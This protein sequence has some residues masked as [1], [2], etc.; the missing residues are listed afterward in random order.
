M[1][2]TK[3]SASDPTFLGLDKYS[4]KLLI[5]LFFATPI[6]AYFAPK[7]MLVIAGIIGLLM[8]LALYRA[9]AFDRNGLVTIGFF[10]LIPLYALITAPLSPV[11]PTAAAM[12]ALRLFAELG[13]AAIILI[14]FLKISATHCH[15][16]V[17]ALFL[18]FMAA[19]IAGVYIGIVVEPRALI[20]QGRIFNNSANELSRGLAFSAIIAAPLLIWIL[21]H[22]RFRNW[23]N[24]AFFLATLLGFM[25]ICGKGTPVLALFVGLFLAWLVF[26]AYNNLKKIAFLGLFIIASFPVLVD[27]SFFDDVICETTATRGSFRH[28]DTIWNFV[29]DHVKERPIVGWGLDSARRFPGGN[30]KVPIL[31]CLDYDVKA[32]FEQVIPLHTHN[33]VLQIWLELGGLGIA[34]TIALIW[35]GM[36]RLYREFYALM[37]HYALTGLFGSLSIVVLMSF[38][39][40]QGWWIATIT[41]SVTTGIMICRTLMQETESE[42][43][44]AAPHT[45]T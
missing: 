36:R 40:W 9:K 7:G 31:F 16:F 28:R 42:D 35:I 1:A 15:K 43:R 2:A 12:R 5:L 39:I 21:Q 30:E 20:A 45:M 29:V 19:I 34:L 11:D 3:A 14:G 10:C 13:M 24:A 38:G 22:L 44:T 37:P 4:E 6:A 25:V 33:G 17:V 27:L 18:G 32:P 41:L 26:E 8:A 23:M